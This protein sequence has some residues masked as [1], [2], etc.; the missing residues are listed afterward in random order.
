[1][2]Y[3]LHISPQSGGS[4]EIDEILWMMDSLEG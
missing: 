4:L 2:N 1:M 3:K